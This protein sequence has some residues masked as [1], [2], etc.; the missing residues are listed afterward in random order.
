MMCMFR[1]MKQDRTNFYEL[2]TVQEGR[3]GWEMRLRHFHPDLVAWEEK[4]DPLVWPM[5]H[6]DESSASFGPVTYELVSRNKLEVFVE[7]EEAS[8]PAKLV[9]ERVTGA[10]KKKAAEAGA[11]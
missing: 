2:V 6:A 7:L 3:E 9:F 11:R 1:A 4:G 10:S 5:T 8:E